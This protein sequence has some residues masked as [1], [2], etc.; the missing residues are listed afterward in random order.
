[1]EKNKDFRTDEIDMSVSEQDR[2]ISQLIFDTDFLQKS[3]RK[4]LEANLFTSEIRQTVVQYIFDYYEKYNESPNDSIIEITNNNNFLIGVNEDDIPAFIQYLENIVSIDNTAGKVQELFDKINNFIDKR[5]IQ[6]TI[7]KLTKMKDRIDGSPEQLSRIIHDCSNKLSIKSSMEE[8]DNILSDDIF[9][10]QSWLTRFNLPSIDDAYSGGMSS[11]S[12]VT[13]Q[14]FTGRGKTW[15]ITHLAKIGL[16]MG[17]DVICIVTEMSN[18]KFKQRMRMSLTG[19]TQAEYNSNPIKAREIIRKS[20][21]RNSELHLISEK[22]KM[23]TDFSITKIEDMVIDIEQKTGREQKL[24]L[25]DSPDDM[26]P[27]P[28]KKY[29]DNISRSTAIFSWMRKYCQENNKLLIV[30]AQSQRISESLLWTTSSNIGED[31]NKIRRSTLGISINGFKKEVQ[32]GYIRL[33]VFKNTFGPTMEHAAWIKTNFG[34][35]QLIQEYGQI[36]NLD[37]TDYKRMLLNRGVS[38]KNKDE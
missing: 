5:I 8:T 34:R 19:M 9:L 15:V 11:E 30:T 29:T 4:G 10:E 17:N 27:P 26:S 2:V 6:T 32:G 38:L 3:K 14:G 28:G 21:V 16:R 22:V 20:M 7:S 35:G 24:I 33:L 12:L 31:I 18:A 1:M 23:D 36:K 37:I 13:L 25:I